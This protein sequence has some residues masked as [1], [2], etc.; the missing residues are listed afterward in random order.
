MPLF[1]ADAPKDNSDKTAKVAAK[2]M[3]F[4]LFISHLHPGYPLGIGCGFTRESF[5]EK[6]KPTE[7]E[8]IPS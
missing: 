7:K 6:T 4:M 3:L 5:F 8:Y 2:M 1:S